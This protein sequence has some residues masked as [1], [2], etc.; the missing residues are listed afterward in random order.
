MKRSSLFLLLIILFL[1]ATAQP[2][3]RIVLLYTNDIH[4]RLTG[5]GPESYYTPLTTN[6]DKTTGGF[7]RIAAIIDNEKKQNEGT[8]VI[9]DAGDFL[10]GT[11][12]QHLEAETG[13][14][15]PLMKKMGYD[16]ICIGNHEFDYGPG[17]LAEIV[18]SSSK[19]GELP[20]ILLGNA[21]FSKKDNL[22]DSL[23]ELFNSGIIG[24]KNILVRDGLKIGFFSLMGKVADENAAFAPPVT[25]SKQIP[26]AKKMVKE[27][28]S[29]DCDLIICLSHSGIDPDERGGWKGED[30][31]L[32]EKVNGID[33]I[34]SGHTHTTLDKPLIVNGIPI[35]QAGDY[36]RFVGKLCLILER[37]KIRI[38]ESSLIPVDDRISGNPVIN[39]LIE[40]QI[41]AVNSKILKPFG[42][43]YKKSVAESDFMLVCDEL[44]DVEN[45]NLGP[46]EADAIY[47]YVNKNS[48]AGANISMVATGVIREKILPGI[49]TAPDIFRVMSMGAGSDEL[50]GYPLARVYF[51][52]KELKS[53]IEVISA[54]W[55]S[56]PAN[57]CYYSG[58]KV[59]TDPDG[60]LLK[61]IKKIDIISPDGSL[62]NVDFSKTNKKLYSIAAS[63]YMLKNIGIIKKKSFGLINVV[64]KDVA[65]NSI[66]DMKSA[67]IDID[68]VKDG[69]QEG[70][71]WLALIEYLKS[72]KD[73]NGNGIPEI[74]NKY[75]NPVKTFFPVITK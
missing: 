53:I 51:T 1:P 9:V 31:E 35:V 62:L 56:T 15:I 44:G 16:V 8:T 74:D 60:G 66:T 68:N 34:I 71:E 57:Y 54:T 37:G 7:A 10:M 43:D 23:E 5:F 12:F 20:V 50:P 24:R 42:M 14:Q 19:N 29:E 3:K 38:E 48:A 40:E 70:K 18:S 72:M 32:A 61:K 45:S 13:F 64:P 73:N 2:A 4:S 25:F 33:V 17:K 55:K 36:G 27:L 28:K 49:Q 58:I 6:D 52:G 65:G 59:E 75:R 67:V 69:V 39:E 47:R 26:F 11:L 21:V 30:V 46:L 63:S 41:E 22:D